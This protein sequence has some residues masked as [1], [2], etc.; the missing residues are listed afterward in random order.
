VLGSLG[1]GYRLWRYFPFAGGSGCADAGQ[2]PLLQQ[3][4]AQLGK[5]LSAQVCAVAVLGVVVSTSQG[6]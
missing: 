3:L 5:E 2:A 1:T 4:P 6:R